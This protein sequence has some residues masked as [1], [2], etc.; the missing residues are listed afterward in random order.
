M[1]ATLRYWP[2][3]ALVAVVLVI[4]AAFGGEDDPPDPARPACAD[5]IIAVSDA[6][7]GLLTDAEFR[8][9]MQTVLSK[10]D[11][12]RVEPL[13]RDVLAAITSGTADELRTS[14]ER[15]IPPCRTAIAD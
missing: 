6:Q 8:S 12:T 11:G 10:A 2:V 5:F 13:A 15:L 1:K 3:A 7:D 14:V 4:V 9:E